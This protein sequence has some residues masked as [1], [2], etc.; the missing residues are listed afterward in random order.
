MLSIFTLVPTFRHFA[1][2]YVKWDMEISLL[3]VYYHVETAFNNDYFKTMLDKIRSPKD[4]T[5]RA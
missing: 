1:F 5:Y 4:I 2:F 3:Y